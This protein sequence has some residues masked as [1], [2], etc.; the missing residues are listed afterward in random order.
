MAAVAAM[1]KL[2][3][4]EGPTMSSELSLLEYDISDDWV[5]VR[6]LKD[7]PGS[8]LE[9]AAELKVECVNI[10]FYAK[11]HLQKKPPLLECGVVI[12]DDVV[13]KFLIPTGRTRMAGNGS[14][15]VKYYDVTKPIKDEE[16]EKYERVGI[17]LPTGVFTYAFFES[18]YL[19]RS[20]D[21]RRGALFLID[22]SMIVVQYPMTKGQKK[23]FQTFGGKKVLY[24]DVLDAP[25]LQERK[26]EIK[27]CRMRGDEQ[28]RRY[29]E[30]D[31]K[32]EEEMDERLT[33]KAIE[34]QDK[35]KLSKKAKQK[36][37]Q[38]EKKGQKGPVKTQETEDAFEDTTEVEAEEE[39]LHK[40]K[41][42]ESRAKAEEDTRLERE[43]ETVRKKLEAAE[44]KRQAK[45]MRRVKNLLQKVQ[46]S[47]R[48]GMEAAEFDQDSS[49]SSAESSENG[50][51]DMAYLPSTAV[52][53]AT[54]RGAEDLEVNALAT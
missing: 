4:I 31:K 11:Q 50:A 47:L 15:A 32:W 42:A 16:I 17:R 33:K 7:A 39:R 22:P 14:I 36:A 18:Q 1:A 3:T 53:A 24:F 5:V 41:Q 13:D 35:P 52:E 48:P 43:Q 28:R 40:L 34:D 25:N 37:R 51:G 54:L 6:F 45:A 29:E 26:E 38:A 10:S 46:S 27:R 2:T 12:N 9:I 30:A 44:V 19:A 20:E 23:D 8:G 21:P 49:E